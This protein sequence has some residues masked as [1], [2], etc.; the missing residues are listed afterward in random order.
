MKTRRWLGAAALRV[1]GSAVREAFGVVD[2]HMGSRWQLETLTPANGIVGS[3]GSS[4]L[5]SGHHGEVHVVGDVGAT[6]GG[7]DVRIFFL[8]AGHMD[9][10]KKVGLGN[11]FCI[12]SKSFSGLGN[13]GRVRHFFFLMDL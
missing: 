8:T 11:F 9:W 10:G 12:F 2:E 7:R 6:W 3:D 1:W 5:G 13:N 4:F